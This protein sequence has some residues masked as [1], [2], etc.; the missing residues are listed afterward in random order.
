MVTFGLFA[1]AS[2]SVAI[3]KPICSH[4]RRQSGTDPVSTSPIVNF[5]TEFLGTQVASNSC[6]HRDLGFTGQLGGEWYAVYGDTLWCDAGVT[7]PDADPEGFHGIVRNSISR[8]G[9]DVL[10]VIDLNLN[11]DSPVPHQNEFITPDVDF[12]ETSTYPFGVSS[13]CEVDNTTATGAIFILVSSETTTFGSG[14]AKVEVQNGV[15]TITQ[16]FGQNGWWWDAA[17]SPRYG[18]VTAYRDVNSEYIYLLGGAPNEATDSSFN[19]IYQARV[20]AAD[21]FDLTKYEYWWG[22][23]AGWKSDLLTQFD[24]T[25]AV[26]FNVGQGQMVYN[27]HLQQYIFVHLNPGGP[28]VLLRTATSPEGPWTPDVKVF[29]ADPMPGGLTYAGVAHPYLDPTGQTLTI[30]F[31]NLN[32]QQVIKV[33]F[34]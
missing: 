1:L 32:H 8:L 23:S 3:A 6:S 33:T 27:E 24:D 31:T 30:S 29:T 20:P 13:I 9:N 22:T 18:D 10:S 4:A 34:Q 19:N 15:P 28:D 14:V 2:I 21:A 25:T 17:T 16:R 11:K 7:D 5:K 12:G 26:M